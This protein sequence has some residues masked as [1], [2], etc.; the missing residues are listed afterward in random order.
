ML[1]APPLP[2]HDC[3]LGSSKETRFLYP[4][5]GITHLACQFSNR[6]TKDAN[7]L[8]DTVTNPDVKVNIIFDV[9]SSITALLTNGDFSFKSKGHLKF[10]IEILGNG[11]IPPLS[12]F[13]KKGQKV[14]RGIL[15]IYE[16]VIF[17]SVELSQGVEKKVLVR[18]DDPKVADLLSLRVS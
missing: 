4:E 9:Y 1:V 10:V 16:Y 5:T 2:L 15:R 8:N 11:L 13:S 3:L 18:H 6:L 17:G 14:H 7:F 12:K